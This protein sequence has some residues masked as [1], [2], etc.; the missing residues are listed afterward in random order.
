M[1]Q[2]LTAQMIAED[3]ERAIQRRLREG[4]VRRDAKAAV[5]ARQAAP[6]AV[7]D[8]AIHTAGLRCGAC[9]PSAV[10]AC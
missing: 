4:A 6:A 5:A 9:R 7:H 1:L 3:R 8:P 10:G 2:V